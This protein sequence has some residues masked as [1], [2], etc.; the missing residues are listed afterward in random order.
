MPSVSINYRSSW[1]TL[2]ASVGLPDLHMHDLRHDKA[3]SLLVA[4]DLLPKGQDEAFLRAYRIPSTRPVVPR[5]EP[6]STG[7]MTG[8]ANALRPSS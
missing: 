4:Q 3:R 5:H 2:T 8:F 6:A 7:I 1:K